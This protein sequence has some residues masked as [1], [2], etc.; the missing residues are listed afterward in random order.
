MYRLMIS[1]P[2]GDTPTYPTRP[3]MILKRAWQGLVGLAFS[4]V[5][6]QDFPIHKY[7]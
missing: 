2:R 5:G 3:T 6:R 4:I 1:S 7:K